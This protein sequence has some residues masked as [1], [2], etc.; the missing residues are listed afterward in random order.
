MVDARIYFGSG[1]GRIYC[2]SADSGKVIWKFR[3]DGGIWSSPCVTDSM[4]V[5]GS[6]SGKI[7]GITTEA[8]LVW[9]FP[10]GALINATPAVLDGKIY[11]GSHDGYIYCLGE[12]TTEVQEQDSLNTP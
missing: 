12:D 4:V 5:I 11:C 9:S 7:Y 6:R 1:D 3:T 10:T 8:E 2:L